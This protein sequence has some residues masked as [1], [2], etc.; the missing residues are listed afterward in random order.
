MR[1]SDRTS[2]ETARTFPMTEI[3]KH[4]TRGDAWVVIDDRVF[5]VTSWAMQHPG[6]ADIILA[7]SGGDASREFADVGH[8]SDARE[9]L[10][11]LQIGVLREPTRAELAEEAAAVESKD[12]LGEAVYLVGAAPVGGSGVD[13]GGGNYRRSSLVS[14]VM[15]RIWS[16]SISYPSVSTAATVGVALTAVVLVHR[17]VSS[18]RN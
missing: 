7:C 13:A 11:G 16:L 9:K 15:R 5:D 12:A 17:A 1:V 4:R 10:D 14:T 6:G 18:Y 2:P 8:S 3:A